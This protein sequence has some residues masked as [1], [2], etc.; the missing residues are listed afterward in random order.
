MAR[1]KNPRVAT[2]DQV[3]IVRSEDTVRIEYR[4]PA[5][6]ST[7]IT[8]GVDALRM[9]DQEI[10]DRFNDTIIMREHS[11]AAYHHVAVEVPP[12]RP[13]VRSFA[14]GDQWLPRGDVLR[15]VIA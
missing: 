3:T 11:G 2:R 1:F 13:Q 5:V 7:Y 10:L 8:L 4:D 6:A 15:C 14:A 12:G 9:T